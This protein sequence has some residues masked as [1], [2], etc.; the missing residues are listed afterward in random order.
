MKLSSFAPVAL[1]C[2]LTSV[3]AKIDLA[4]PFNPV[5]GGRSTV[6]WTH[7]ASDPTEFVLMLQLAS[8]SWALG[9]FW[10]FTQTSDN[11]LDVTWLNT[12]PYVIT[13]VRSIYRL[14]AR[15]QSNVDQIYARSPD[16]RFLEPGSVVTTSSS[17]SSSTSTLSSSVSKPS[18]TQSSSVPASITQTSTTSTSV[19]TTTVPTTTVPTTT[20]TTS[21]TS[22]SDSAT[23]TSSDTAGATGAVLGN[24][25]SAAS[26]L[27][28][29]G[30]AALAAMLVVSLASSLF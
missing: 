24:N 23:T 5:S 28:V 6:T 8:D 21:T 20:S 15:N 22:T 16:F 4:A 19:P 14:T 3:Y 12:D 29:N 25:D 11:K 7:D 9:Q 13:P 30:G 18:L 17:V 10:E 26:S 2:F 1:T 27:P